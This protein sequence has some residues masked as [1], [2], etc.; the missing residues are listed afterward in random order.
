MNQD[1]WQKVAGTINDGLARPHHLTFQLM[2]TL[3]LWGWKTSVLPRLKEILPHKL[4]DCS[5]TEFLKF[6]DGHKLPDH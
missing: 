5:I 1:S 4:P 6:L 3:N 2:C